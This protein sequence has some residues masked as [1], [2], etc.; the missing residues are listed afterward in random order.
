MAIVSTESN[1]PNFPDFQYSSI[2]L[3]NTDTLYTVTEWLNIQPSPC[4]LETNAPVCLWTTPAFTKL[5]TVQLYDN[6]NSYNFDIL[7]TG[8]QLD[9]IWIFNETNPMATYNGNTGRLWGSISKVTMWMP[10]PPNN[11]VFSLPVQCL[12]RS[13][14]DGKKKKRD[15]LVG[16]MFPNGFTIY[17]RGYGSEELV[18]EKIYYYDGTNN[19]VRMDENGMTTL[20]RGTDV[21]RYSMISPATLSP[22]PCEYYSTEAMIWLP[23]YLQEPVMNVTIDS[24]PATVW[25]AYDHFVPTR[26]QYWYLDK[27]NNPVYIIDSSMMGA[28]VMFFEPETP[29]AGVFDVPGF[30]FTL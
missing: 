29:P 20:Q 9:R 28:K 21:Y 12:P 15:T 13:D 7:G 16:P 2:V 30:C 6:I 1:I 10:G 24:Q 3:N 18:V 25:Q 23:P 19:F 27:T 4:Q 8:P 17:V 26:Y 5:S 11:A 14:M 22:F